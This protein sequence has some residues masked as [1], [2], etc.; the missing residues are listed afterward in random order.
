MYMYI[1][2][3][4][5]DSDEHEQSDHGYLTITQNLQTSMTALTCD[6][7]RH[8]QAS[9]L[10]GLIGVPADRLC[11]KA[12]FPIPAPQSANYLSVF[13]SC[14]INILMINERFSTSSVPKLI[15]WGYTWSLLGVQGN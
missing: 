7:L 14:L 2:A 9:S 11:P 15:N 6:G 13:V 3:T 12:T 4:C 10:Q 1:C 5:E 8:K